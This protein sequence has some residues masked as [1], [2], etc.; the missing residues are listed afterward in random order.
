MKIPLWLLFLGIFTITLLLLILGGE[1]AQNLVLAFFA[2][3]LVT[4]GAAAL[5]AKN[6]DSHD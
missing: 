5:V 2:A 4:M 6:N 1:L 3:C